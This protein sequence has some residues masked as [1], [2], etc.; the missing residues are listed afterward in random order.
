MNRNF[1]GLAWAKAAFAVCGLMGVTHGMAAPDSAKMDVTAVINPGTECNATVN[2]STFDYGLIDTTRLDKEKPTA[3]E[4]KSLELR[5]HCA[6]FASRLV[7]KIVS[8]SGQYEGEEELWEAIPDLPRSTLL[9]NVVN[10]K[11]HSV[12]GMLL[13]PTNILADGKSATLLVSD[14]DDDHYDFDHHWRPQS[15]PFRGFTNYW[16]NRYAAGDAI[17]GTVNPINDLV[18]DMEATPVIASEAIK[19]LISPLQF[20]SSFTIEVTQI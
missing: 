11:N 15:G 10:E 5:I 8:S 12:G 17:N 19:G 14:G 16:I 4:P 9:F 6:P 7:F 2:P 20:N 18:L 13:K 1:F 3:L